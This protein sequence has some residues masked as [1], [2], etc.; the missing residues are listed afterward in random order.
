MASVLGIAACGSASASASPLKLMTM[1]PVSSPQFSI[2]SIPDGAQIAVNN[3][4]KSGGVNGRKLEL[5]TCNDQ[6]S[7]NL[8]ATCARE[9]IK[10]KVVALVGGLEDYD[11][12]IEPLLK[13]IPWVGLTTADDYTAKNLFLFPGQGA[14]AF[15]AAGLALTQ[16]GCKKA[17][18]VVTSAA[19]TET[20]NIADLTAGLHAG[21]ASVTTSITIPATQVDMSSTAEAVRAS[22]AQC[23]A[24][25][26]SPVQSGPLITALNSS[27]SALGF[28]EAAGGLP[29]Q[30]VAQLGSAANGVFATGGFLPTTAGGLSKLVSQMK[31]KYPKVGLDNFAE[32]GYASVLLVAKVATGLGKNK[33]TA[34][35]LMSALNKK[36]RNF[37]TGVGPV[38]SSKGLNTIP[39]FGRLF[40]AENFVYVAK[41]G[42][43]V[44]SQPKPIN[45]APALKLLNK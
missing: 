2:P 40:S 5:I 4:N 6:N 35:S 7:P 34:S 1:G 13:G 12:Q 30:V 21:G 44:L 9:A 31:A 23:V 22:G 39:G 8:A 43:Y 37:N 42:N 18:I 28:A 3:I 10:D 45:V 29:P 33:I 26:T 36:V 19:G 32:S 11:L 41:N 25:G 38:V 27:G 24:S 15:A 20:V 16:H 17:A 14:D